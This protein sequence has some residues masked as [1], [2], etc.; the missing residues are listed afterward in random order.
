MSADKY[1]SI[2]MSDYDKNGLFRGVWARGDC[3]GVGLSIHHQ[4]R[5]K[6]LNF[7]VVM[8][9]FFLVVLNVLV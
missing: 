1:N 2:A 3:F 7:I 5:F 9:S 4:A 8:I 6:R